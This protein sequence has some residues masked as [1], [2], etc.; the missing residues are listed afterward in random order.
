MPIPVGMSHV[1]RTI[2]MSPMNDR[3]QFGM[4]EWLMYA[5]LA[6]S[7]VERSGLEDGKS[8]SGGP[9]SVVGS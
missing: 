8:F 9:G 3:A 5:A 1:V 6:Q 7:L 2:I 4:Q